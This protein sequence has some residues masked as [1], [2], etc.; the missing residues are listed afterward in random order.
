VIEVE[1]LGAPADERVPAAGEVCR[2]VTLA[3]A[4]ASVQEGHLAIEFVDEARI[5]QLNENFRGRRSATDVLSFPIDG[6]EQIGGGVMR[7]L[8]DL[9]ICLERTRDV[10]EAIVHGVLHLVGFDHET[11]GGEMLALQRRLLAAWGQ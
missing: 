10:R 5:A 4:A 6:D 11:D 1:I 7:E 9:V 3:A 8:G 2:L